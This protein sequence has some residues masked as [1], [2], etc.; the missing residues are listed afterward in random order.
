MNRFVSIG[1][2]AIGHRNKLLAGIAAL[3]RGART[4]L[5]RAA[6]SEIPLPLDRVTPSPLGGER[7]HLTVM[8]CDLVGSTEIAGRLDPEEWREI[9][10]EYHRQVAAAVTRFG[11]HVAKNLGDGALVYFGYPRAQENDSERAARAGLAILEAIAGQHSALAAQGGPELRVRV[12][13]HAGP[14]V[15]GEDSEVYGEVP[16]IAARVQAA[17]EPGM[18]LITRDVHL[19]VSGRF[20]VADR[21]AQSLKGVA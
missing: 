10:I 13:I 15:I 1:V 18:V 17:A 4:P 11:G 3:G 2:V 8:F 20:V 14:V 9:V 6:T 5:L 7:R 12:G 21:G 16:N 19:Q